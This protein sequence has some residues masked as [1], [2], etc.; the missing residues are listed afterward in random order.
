M[1]NKKIRRSIVVTSI[2]VVLILGSLSFLS[3][4]NDDFKLV[5]SLEIYYSLFRE[6]NMFYV[7]E[8]DPEKLVE[9][10]I[11]GMLEELD[12]YTTFI[13]ESEEENFNF[14]TTGEYGGIGAL[15][16]R[17]G[18]YAIIAEPYQGFPAQ[19]NDL[20]AGDTI[21][22]IDGQSM[23]GKEISYISEQLKGTPGTTLK[24]TLK[25][26]DVEKEF[27]KTLIRE[28]INIS[29][30]PYY[31][32]VDSEIGYIRLA[33]FTTDAAKE[34]KKAF[35]ELEKEYQPSGIIIDVRGN[36]G[37]LL[38]EAVD[39]AGFFVEYGQEIVSTKGRVNQ[40]DYI[41]KTRNSPVDTKIPLVVLVNRSS[42]SASEI[43]AGSMQDLDR[44]VIVGQRT[45]GKGLVQTT[46]NLAY[47]SKLKV[48]T[49]KYY[50][51]SGRCIQALDFSNRNEDG[52]VG[53]IPDSLI[54]EFSTLNGRKV[55]DG[56][57]IL[58][59]IE[60]KAANLSQFSVSLYTQNIIFDYA[61][62][63]V[64]RHD[65]IPPVVNFDITNE[66]YSDFENYVLNRNFTYSTRSEESLKKLIEISRQEKYYD[67]AISEFSALEE[68]LM[69]DNA[70]DLTHF[71]D[72]ISYL[73]KQEIVSR[74]YYQW[75][76]MEAAIENDLEVTKA[77]EVLKDPKTYFSLLAV[78]YQDVHGTTNE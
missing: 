16:R 33:N 22:N 72:E 24:I 70:K 20:R 31:G 69:H 41:Y 59:D 4:N 28:K 30:V 6:L 52:S 71:K 68:K 54:S 9:S 43:L 78:E 74:Y 65:S 48:T 64:S 18:D 60:T 73:L 63:Y 61:T 8:T 39:I 56:G 62:L 46:R 77:I 2:I 67:L 21:L 12:P 10:S 51:P 19:K 58:P 57:G 23:K 14:M 53:V 44:G 29:N 76:S 32:M 1:K 5:K 37:G 38:I 27:E 42:A 3:F 26:I 47:N 13:P 50:I 66:I 7:D 15:I 17:S 45:Y 75:G 34:V 25:R 49:A 36:P 55:Y 35:S 40:W 11:D